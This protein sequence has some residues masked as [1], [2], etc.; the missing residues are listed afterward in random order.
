MLSKVFKEV[1]PVHL[2]V[3]VHRLLAGELHWIRGARLPRLV[4]IPVVHPPHHY[5]CAYCCDT[6]VL[7]R[8]SRHTARPTARAAP[9]RKA[10]QHAEELCSQRLCAQG[11]LAPVTKVIA[12]R[13]PRGSEELLM[14]VEV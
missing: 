2:S 1:M 14:Q 11:L 4:S 8:D 3:A 6:T 10:W 5:L 9:G 13:D 12:V 7:T